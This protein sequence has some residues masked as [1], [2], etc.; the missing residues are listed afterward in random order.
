MAVGATLFR[1]PSAIE[2][3]LLFFAMLL[4]LRIVFRNQ[5]LA[6]AAFVAIWTVLK[7]LGSQHPGIDIAGRSSFMVLPRLRLFASAW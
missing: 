7:V 1:V 5:W 6:A 3:T 2:G 4:V